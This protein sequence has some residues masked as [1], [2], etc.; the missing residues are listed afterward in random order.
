MNRS[1]NI[2]NPEIINKSENIPKIKTPI[3]V[4]S[5]MNDINETWYNLFNFILKFEEPIIY[6]VL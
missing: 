6:S 2:R 1:P 5:V 3:G 4:F